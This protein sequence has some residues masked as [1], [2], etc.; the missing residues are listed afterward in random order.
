MLMLSHING[1][2]IHSFPTL[3]LLFLTLISFFLLIS[4]II[5][6]VSLTFLIPFTCLSPHYYLP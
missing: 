3:S 2:I 1:R 6:I 5:V 4:Q